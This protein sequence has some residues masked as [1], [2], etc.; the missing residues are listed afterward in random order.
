M[1]ANAQSAAPAWQTEELQDEWIELDEENGD[2][3]DDDL[4]YG[5][6]SISLTAPLAT[7]IYTNNDGEADASLLRPPSPAA[8]GTFLIREDVPSEPLLAKTPGRQKKGI[9]KDFFSPLPLERM[10]EPPSPPPQKLK[11][12]KTHMI[13]APSIPSQPSYLTSIDEEPQDEI[14]ETDIPDMKSFH[15]KKANI[16]CRFTFAVPRE[17]LLTPNKLVDTGAFSQAQST[18]FPL[19]RTAPNT[20]PRLRLFQFQYDTYTREHLSAMVDSIALNSGT[21][22]TPSP[23]SLNHLSRVSE[24]DGSVETMS[25]L[26]SAKRVKL[27]PRSDYEEGEGEGEG[28]SIARPKVLGKDY[29]G[30]SKSLMQQIK[31]ARDFSTISTLASSRNASP[32]VVNEHSGWPSSSVIEHSNGG[33]FTATSYRQQAATLMAQI[34]NDMKGPKRLFSGDTATSYARD[35]SG[36]FSSS[37]DAAVRPEDKENH[38]E[39]FHCKNPSTKPAKSKHKPSP[40]KSRRLQAEPDNLIEHVA[41]LSLHDRRSFSS[42]SLHSSHPSSTHRTTSTSRSASASLS[43]RPVSTLSTAPSSLAPPAYPSSSLR[44]AD[45][46]NRFVSSSTAS[47]TTLTSTSVPSFVKHAGPPHIRTI[48]PADIP[49]VPEVYNGMLFDRVM[50]RWVKNTARTAQEPGARAPSEGPSEDP[51]GDIESLRDDS[52]E[53]GAGAEAAEREMSRIEE[54]EEEVVDSFLTD[55]PAGGVI[56]M[57]MDSFQ[58]DATTDSDD[59]H[60]DGGVGGFPVFSYYEAQESLSMSSPPMEAHLALPGTT[61]TPAIRSAMKNTPSKTTPLNRAHRRSVSF[62][63]GKREGP[64]QGL[65][66]STTTDGE[67]VVSGIVQSVRSK[68]IAQMVEALEEDDGYTPAKTVTYVIHE[69]AGLTRRT[70]ANATFLTECSFAVSHDRL[71]EVLTDVE[72]FTPHWDELSSIDLSG[73]R[74]ESVARL[75]EFLPRLDALNLQERQSVVVAEWDPGVGADAVRCIK[76]SLRVGCRAAELACLRHLR[77]LKADGNKITSVEGLERMDGLVKL[78]LQG[79]TIEMGVADNNELGELEVDGRMPKLRVLRASGNRL[80]ELRVGALVNLR[81]LYADNNCLTSLVEVER[82]T[83]LENLSVRNQSGRGLKLLTRDVRDVKRLYLSG[84]PLQDGFLNEACYNL[85]YLEAAGCRLTAVPADMGRLVPNLRVLN[86]N[87]NFISDVRG[88]EGLGRL[89]KLSLVGSRVGSTRALVRLAGALGDAE[90]LDFRMNPC[91]LG[92]Y[93]P[94][95]VGGGPGSDGA[96]RRDL[97]DGLYL[98]RLGY[99]GRVMGGCSGLRVLDGVVV[100]EKERT[101]AHEMM[102][103]LRLHATRS[104]IWSELGS[105]GALKRCA[106]R[107]PPIPLAMPTEHTLPAHELNSYNVAQL[108]YALYAPSSVR[109]RELTRL[110][111]DSKTDFLPPDLAP[112]VIPIEPDLDYDER[113]MSTSATSTTDTDSTREKRSLTPADSPQPKRTKP[114]ADRVQLPSIFTTLDE[115]YR[116]VSP[117]EPYRRASLPTLRHAPYPRQSYSPPAQPPNL[118]AYTFP[119]ADDSAYLFAPPAEPEWPAPIARPSS[120]PDPRH[121]SQPALFAG[122]ARISGQDRRIKSEWSFP[123][124]YSPP[125]P[126]AAAAGPPVPVPSSPSRSPAA[127]PSSTLVDRPQRKRGKLPKETTDYLKAW[128]HRHSDHPYPSEEEKKQLCH[129][130]GLSMSQVSNWMIN[131][132]RRILAPAHRAASGPTTTAPFPPTARSTSLSGLLDHSAR[133]ASMPSAESLQLYHPMTLQSMPSHHTEYASSTRSMLGGLPLMRGTLAP[134]D[135]TQSQRHHMAMYSQGPHSAGPSPSPHHYNISSD[136]P[137]SAPPYHPYP[138]FTHSPRVPPAQPEPGYFNDAHSHSG[139]AP[140]SGYA[141]PQ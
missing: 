19:T 3:E 85:Q 92:W 22:T 84:N 12:E 23:P 96:F 2:E 66:E 39:V 76:Q 62:S 8:G 47:G 49:P 20:D 141:T 124:F 86:L 122:S 132:R 37:A 74:L 33:S 89:R 32:P 116:R 67:D 9:I 134:T 93:L 21:G 112:H 138:S 109:A 135:Y 58:D 4:T 54:R 73:K 25:R 99:R 75:K 80:R 94:V 65:E 83:R 120:T 133:R 5:T 72:P 46:L 53:R 64:I 10:F 43:S 123:E 63:D 101:K 38:R 98:G 69:E 114:D 13:P 115:P 35:K 68:R 117:D 140:G 121:A 30:E 11:A 27:S 7:H 88:L 34:K 77:E 28:A 78:S 52:R 61:N 1:P 119:P 71:V 113:R 129:A 18:P 102:D 81:T 87:Y 70:T 40:K 105:L 59:D 24:V 126:A 41:Q 128:L 91:T 125:M 26:R 82:L 29:V 137:L 136:V 51:F 139:S 60:D 97:P 42:S 106:C 16:S 31:Q 107:W 45:D 79:N 118:A 6:R 44:T 48:A 103:D 130:T 50:M 15:G 95:V 36:S 17:S 104:R 111:S 56:G 131:A 57:D 108:Q 90:E 14:V 100:T 110:R 127:V 55:E